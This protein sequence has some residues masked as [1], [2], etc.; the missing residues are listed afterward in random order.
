MVVR[1]AGMDAEDEGAA[2]PVHS[3]GLSVRALPA[4][5]GGKVQIAFHAPSRIPG[6]APGD[7]TV[8]VDD[9][10]GRRVAQLAAGAMPVEGEMITV[11]WDGK[12]TGGDD[13]APGVYFV[14]AAAPSVGFHTERR[15]VVR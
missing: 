4:R 1:V 12:E 8:E 13:I 2:Q 10:S 6:H 3:D 7:L 5:P 11:A 15:I 14:R 9:V